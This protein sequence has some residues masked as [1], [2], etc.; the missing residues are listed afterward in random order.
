MALPFE[1]YQTTKSRNHDNTHDMTINTLHSMLSPEMKE[2]LFWKLHRFSK[3]SLIKIYEKFEEEIVKK[4][5][6]NPVNI[7]QL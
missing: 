5:C 7:P 3:K 1:R 2:E 6:N 4:L